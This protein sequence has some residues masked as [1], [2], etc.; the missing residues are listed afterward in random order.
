MRRNAV[1]A[2]MR[3]GLG[4]SG[5]GGGAHTTPAPTLARVEPASHPV[6]SRAAHRPA[7]ALLLRPPQVP[8]AKMEPHR[9]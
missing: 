6:A 5:R 8:G 7:E 2:A 3:K 4:G 1:Q 9:V